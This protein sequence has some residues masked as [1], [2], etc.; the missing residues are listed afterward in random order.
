VREVVQDLDGIPKK[1]AIK[2][3]KTV[4]SGLVS[5]SWK[6]LIYYLFCFIY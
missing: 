1:M 3:A 6:V 2:A 4:I 5:A